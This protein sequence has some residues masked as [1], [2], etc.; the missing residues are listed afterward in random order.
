[1]KTFVVKIG[2][3]KCEC[4]IDPQIFVGLPPETIYREAVLASVEKLCELPD[5]TL[6]IVIC[7]YEKNHENQ[8][9]KHYFFNTYYVLIGFRKYD[10][11][12]KLLSRVKTQLG[13]D[14]ADEND[15]HPKK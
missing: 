12:T 3:K 4:V 1:M 8:M 10:V 13:I 15:V 5:A 14:L 11:A 7:C 2:E 6:S 9:D